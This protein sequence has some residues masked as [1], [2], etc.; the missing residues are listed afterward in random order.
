MQ[1]IFGFSKKQI[2]GIAIFISITS[3][4]SPH[5]ALAVVAETFR[6]V[7]DGIA[8]GVGVTIHAEMSAGVVHA[9]V[10]AHHAAADLALT[11]VLEVLGLGGRLGNVAK[12]VRLRQF[13]R[14]EIID[15]LLVGVPNAF[16][17]FAVDAAVV[18]DAVFLEVDVLGA[19]GERDVPALGSPSVA[20]FGEAFHYFGALVGRRF[21]TL[22]GVA[23]EKL[24][25]F[26]DEI[27]LDFAVCLHVNEAEH[28]FF[29][30]AFYLVAD[31]PNALEDF[32]GRDGGR[33]D[34][35]V[36]P[37]DYALLAYHLAEFLESLDAEGERRDVGLKTL[38]FVVVHR[39]L[40][41]VM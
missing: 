41:V 3:K 23:A 20:A 30:A 26:L 31:S 37:P 33:Q 11:F 15:K 7:A 29:G 27:V 14:A 4:P 39:E 40:E 10:L 6:I 9:D 25:G 17:E 38:A 21:G 8:A 13:A 36:E 34:Y 32:A 1:K 2:F 12:E 24:G 19:G 35:G 16:H 18:G 22:H 28:Q 5:N